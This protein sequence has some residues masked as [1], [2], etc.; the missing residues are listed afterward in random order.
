MQSHELVLSLSIHPGCSI[1]W[2]A[3]PRPNTLWT[4]GRTDAV[5]KWDLQGCDGSAAPTDKIAMK[6]ISSFP[7]MEYLG[8]GQC[9]LTVESCG[10]ELLAAPGPGQEGITVWDVQTHKRRCVL[11]PKDVKMYGTLMQCSW[12]HRDQKNMILALY[13]S[14]KL[15]I[16]NL[17]DKSIITEKVLI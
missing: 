4:L 2:L 14:G 17:D 16:W 10:S 6:E 7:V 12:C 15:C 5:K 1:Q 9:S 3:S 8:F 13:E 11:M